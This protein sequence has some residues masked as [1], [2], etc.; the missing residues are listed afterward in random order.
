MAQE[1]L[2]TI[3]ELMAEVSQ[4]KSQVKEIEQQAEATKKNSFYTPQLDGSMVAYFNYNP[5][6]QEERFALRNAQ[7]AVRGN[8]SNNIT[9]LIQVNYHNLAKVS[10]LDSYIRY[11]Y[12]GFNSTIGQQWIHLTTDFDRCGPKSNIFTSRSYGVVFIPMYSTETSLSTLGNRDIGLYSNYTFGGAIP[13]TLS[14]GLFNGLGANNLAWDRTTNITGRIMIG[15][16][17][18]LAGGASLYTG[19]TPYDQEITIWSAET[20]YVK[21]GF[22]VEANYQQRRLTDFSTEPMRL[23]QTGLLQSYYIIKTPKSKLF[24]SFAPT[25]RYDFGRG[26]DYLNEVTDLVEQHDVNRITAVM[27]MNLK[28]AKIKSRLGIGYEEIFMP[29]KPSDMEENALFQDRFT[30]SL[31]VAF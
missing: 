2:P 3:Q 12:K 15:G 8:A 24:D 7:I 27:N 19:S 9:Y 23:T 26:V 31:T 11:T 30:I 25:V 28:G 10:V 21:G 6:T 16:K 4:L 14:F 22:F 18:G 17:E 5:D 13:V 20:R 29:E 1:D